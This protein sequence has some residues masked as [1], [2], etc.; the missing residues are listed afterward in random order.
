[1]TSSSSLSGGDLAEIQQLYA[2]YNHAV[3]N[4]DGE[5]FASCFVPDGVLEGSGPEPVAG[6]DALRAFAVSVGQGLP[7]IRHFAANVMATPSSSAAQ[8]A[9]DTAADG[10]CY[11]MVYV[12]QNGAPQFLITGRY[13]DELRRDAG[14]WRFVRRQFEADST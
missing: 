3:D 14:G 9:A 2:R 7:G 11:L 12:A 4:G 10:R 13:R 1:V 8:D 6:H 5:M